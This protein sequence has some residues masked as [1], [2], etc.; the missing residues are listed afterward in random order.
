[1]SISTLLSRLRVKPNPRTGIRH[2]GRRIREGFAGHVAAEGTPVFLPHASTDP[3]VKSPV[4]RARGVRALYGVP[5]MRDGKAIGVAHIGSL[6]ANEFSDEDKLLFRTMASRATSVIVRQILD[7]LRRT[8]RH[9]D[10]C[11]RRAGSSRVAGC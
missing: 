6:T 7:D 1:M 10:S 8:E 3:I 5:L 9:S 4:I 11:R 2:I